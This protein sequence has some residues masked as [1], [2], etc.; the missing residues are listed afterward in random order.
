MALQRYHKVILL[1][2]SMIQC[3]LYSMDKLHD[4][5]IGHLTQ[6]LTNNIGST[7]IINDKDIEVVVKNIKRLSFVDKNLYQAINSKTVTHIL[8]HALAQRF[9]ISQ[10]DAA[11]KL[12]TPGTLVWLKNSV[13]NLP[14]S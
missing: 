4:I 2:L 13:E 14:N 5:V 3:S 11:V 9:N 1:F 6:C 8:I 10:L 12:N 7:T